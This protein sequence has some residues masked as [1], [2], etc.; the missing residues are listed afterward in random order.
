MSQ[1]PFRNSSSLVPT[2][3]P[4][5]SSEEVQIKDSLVH[6]PSDL[7][8]EKDY[9]LAITEEEIPYGDYVETSESRSVFPD[10]TW[11]AYLLTPW[12]ISS[13]LF[14]LIANSILT[15]SQWSNAQK[16]TT[17]SVPKEISQLKESPLL[18]NAPPVAVQSDKLN[19]MNLSTVRYERVKTPVVKSISPVPNVPAAPQPAA[20]PINL[21]PNI[22]PVPQSPS[23][24]SNALLPPSLR[25]Q[26]VQSYTVPPSLLSQPEPPPVTP[27]LVPVTPAVQSNPVLPP[28]PPVSQNT[29]PAP[30]LTS[31]PTLPPSTPTLQPTE[32]T[33]VPNTVQP[34]AQPVQTPLRQSYTLN[35]DEAS[36]LVQQLQQLQQQPQIQQPQIQQPQ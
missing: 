9:L 29:L 28:P 12:G 6:N 19:L 20:H 35:A 21:A 25:P 18:Q 13:I 32:N 11:L 30:T 17:E 36:S 16:L 1:E 27:Q 34:V 2:A 7:E 3:K 4:Q 5:K 31:T 23:N 14:L 26:V 33:I 22:L 10:R 24:L 15:L 8:E